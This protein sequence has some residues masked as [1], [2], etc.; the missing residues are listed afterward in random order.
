[1]QSIGETEDS[2]RGPAAEFVAGAAAV[3]AK[4]SAL[5]EGL[6]MPASEVAPATMFPATGGWGWGA[7]PAAPA[8]AT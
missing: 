5:F 8:P 2:A 7:A 6:T 4:V 1:M 3:E